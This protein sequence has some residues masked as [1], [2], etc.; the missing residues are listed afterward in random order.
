MASGTRF[1]F[2]MAAALFLP[3]WAS[4]AA[5]A[6]PLDD[7]KAAYGQSDFPAAQKLLR[8]LADQGNPEAQL[9]IGLMYDNG[10]GVKK[11]HAE[12]MTW[13]RKA[14]ANGNM[15]ALYLV[16][17][18]YLSDPKPNYAEAAKML[19]KPAEQGDSDAQDSLGWLL[20]T[21]HGVTQD[22]DEGRKWF[23]RSANQGNQ[24]G[25]D[26]A[27]ESYMAESNESEIY[28]W[29]SIMARTNANYTKYRDDEAGFIT[30]EQKSAVDARLQQW[31]PVPE[32][33]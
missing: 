19:R 31:K 26:H 29:Y 25:M 4:S 20:E 10:Q 13:F 30:P 1:S 2:A 24:N 6:A 16:G 17:E 15:R 12:A 21:G 23:L 14:G 32:K 8:P 33:Q 7:G 3:L 9:Y 18:A 22:V 27:A 5:M 28:F 11:N